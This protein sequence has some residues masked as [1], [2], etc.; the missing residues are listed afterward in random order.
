MDYSQL[1]AKRKDRF[2]ELEE[3]IG[4]P[5]LFDDPKRATEILRE[6]RKLQQTLQVWDTF[7]SPTTKSSLVPMIKNSPPWPQRKSQNSRNH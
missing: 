3:A 1:I 7:S 4:D 6:H 5:N 2:R